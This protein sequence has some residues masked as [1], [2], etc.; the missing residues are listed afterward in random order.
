MST[1]FSA[2]NETGRT[3]NGAIT[4]LSSMS[5]CVD[6]FGMAGSMR[7]KDVTQ[8]FNR[9]FAEDFDTAIRIALWVRDCRGG[10]G[11]RSAFKQMLHETMKHDLELAGRMIRKIPKLGYWKDIFDFLDHP[12]AIEMLMA[13][14]ESMVLEN[15]TSLLAKYMPRKGKTAIKLRQILDMPPKAY[16]KLIVKHSKTT[17]QLM[18]AKEWNK[19]NYD[20]VPSLCHSRNGKAFMRN[21]TDRYNRYLSAVQKGEKSIKAWAVYPYDVVKAVFHGNAAQADAQ[22]G[23]LPNYMEGSDERILPVVDTSGSMG[24]YAGG[25]SSLTCKD[26]AISLGL[27]ISER[28]EGIFKD[29]FI[30]FSNRPRM[31]QVVGKTLRDRIN[32]LWRAQWDMNTDL[33]KTFRVILDSAIRC[34]VPE[35]QMPTKILIL[36]DMEFDGCTR[37]V[38][39][40]QMIKDLYKK[41]GYKVPGIIFWNLNAR[42]GNS[43]VTALDKNTAL[44]SGFSPSILKSILGAEDFDPT[45]IM[46]ETISSDRYN[47]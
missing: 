7:N 33:E 27:Y 28:N 45:K 23:A 1:L 30:T 11:E 15:R 19:I 3:A 34:N 22:W 6:L 17:E 5:D 2:M 16:R 36:S 18:S 39:N 4:N 47:Y 12:V 13:E 38:T 43:P 35:D 31:Q 21:D 46:M 42:A 44:V 40:M 20:Q 24:C 41:H 26:V 37:R 8:L 10:A 9:A 32:N 25:N 29:Q 14:V